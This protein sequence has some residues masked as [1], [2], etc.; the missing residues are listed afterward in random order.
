MDWRHEKEW[1]GIFTWTIALYG[2][3]AMAAEAGLSEKAYWDQIIKACFLDQSDPIAK[4]KQVYRDLE[5]YRSKLN[6]LA[7]KTDRLHAV[8][9][10]MDLWNQAWRKAQLA[11]GQR[12]Q[13]SELR[14]VHFP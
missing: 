8:G 10:D 14:T 3:K 6:K 11:R 1:K 4:W 2:T 12:P 5:S 13:H 7:P 9:P